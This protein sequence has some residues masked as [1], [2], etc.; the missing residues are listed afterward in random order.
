VEIFTNPKIKAENRA[1][2]PSDF[3]YQEAENILQESTPNCMQKTFCTPTSWLLM[4]EGPI[5]GQV[6]YFSLTGE[7]GF[8]HF[9]SRKASWSDHWMAL[10]QASMVWAA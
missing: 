1:L 2:N 8:S 5:A 6:A 7:G 9:A 3:F 4:L 10:V